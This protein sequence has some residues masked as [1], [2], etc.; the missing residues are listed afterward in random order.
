M[1]REPERS[2]WGRIILLNGPPSFGK[3]TLARA[4]Q[5][6]LAVPY[7]HCSLD[8]FRLGY[9]DRHWLADDGT[10]FRRVLEGYLLSLQ[11]MTSLGH[12]LIAETVI[13][14][15]RLERYL[16][17]FADGPVLFVGVRCPLA[18][19]QRREQ[20]R[21]DRLKGPVEL[22]VPDFDLVHAHGPYD[23][24][25]DTS[26]TTPTEAARRIEEVLAAPPAPTAFERL[27]RH[28][29]PE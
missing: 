28:E 14:P 19:A 3:T 13:T 24:D 15:D 18:E 22:A 8:H 17:L 4:L 7:F 27:R 1:T 6:R 29:A 10:L 5:E 23:L 20:A 16:A 12:N 11:T 25:I 9:L 2:T 26:R 21:R